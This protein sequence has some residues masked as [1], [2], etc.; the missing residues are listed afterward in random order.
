[1]LCYRHRDCHCFEE[2]TEAPLQWRKQ[3][4]ELAIAKYLIW[5]PHRAHS[6]PVSSWAE[7][8]QKDPKMQTKAETIWRHYYSEC[9]T[10]C[11]TR[12]IVV[13]FPKKWTLGSPYSGYSSSTLMRHNHL[14]ISPGTVGKPTVVL[15][16]H[17]CQALPIMRA[18]LQMLKAT[19]CLA[20]RSLRTLYIYFSTKKCGSSHILQNITKFR[21]K[22]PW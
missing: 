10:Q 15:H 6:T 5:N 3:K 4:K 14:F 1:M 17:P 18:S 9:V 21:A 11:R 12:P 19:N 2:V 22:E 13:D 7:T 16:S 8:I 20:S